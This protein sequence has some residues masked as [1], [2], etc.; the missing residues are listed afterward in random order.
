MY[1]VRKVKTKSGS[2]AIQVVQYFGH[3]SKV[4]KHI[5]SSN[6]DAEIV[7]LQ[8]KALDWIEEQTS[9]TKLFQEQKQKILLVDRSECIA[10]THNFTF[11]FFTSCIEECGLS[12]L[13]SLI[14][15][16][17]IM[18][19]IEPASK[20][21]SI[22]LLSHYFGIKYS[23]RIYRN[24]PKLIIHKSFIEECAYNIARERFNEPFYFVLYD[25]TT[26]YFESFN[27]DDFKIQGFS[28]DN[29]SQQPQIVIGLLTTQSGFPLSYQV[30]AGNTFEGKTMLPIVENFVL[31]HPKTKPIIV[32]DAAML[33]EERLNEL[34]QKKISYIVGARLSNA[35]LELIK[36]IHSTLNG[37]H[38][39]IARFSSRHGDLICDFSQK[40][41]KKDLND[42]NK[43]IQKAN[44]L[45]A[46]QSLGTKAKFVKR[47]SKEKIELNTE[48]IEKR[49][50]IL[51]I[52]GYCTNLPEK[53]L[54]NEV[55]IERYHQ[56]WHIEQSFRMSKF[57]LQSR[58]IYHQNEDAIRSHI[59][60]C[61][62]ALI[63]E[64]YLEITTKLS[65]R[66][67]RFLVWN[68]TEI[69][70][71]DKL[72]KEKFKFISPTDKIVKSNL[73]QLIKKWNLLPH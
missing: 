53:Q 40:R 36:K 55:V 18:R 69:Y 3:R 22:E 14:I 31:Q 60:I 19:L 8:R 47:I 33:D 56:L 42:L 26:L 59:L 44:E 49:K 6:I 34:K 41:Y 4:F 17:S 68:I 27:A 9:Q 15:D 11:Q 46:K 70:I 66:E 12:G 43:L 24:I 52:K 20:Q 45:V 57:D 48:L 72:T 37:K 71:Q 5:G 25:V 67:I 7:V 38:G 63:I 35:N 54:S 10:V 51:G 61:F 39:A 62:V 50:L 30:F 29:K 23:Q 28:K 13:P 65:L 73:S 58:P 32:A 64:K 2:T 21:R 1:S 16:L